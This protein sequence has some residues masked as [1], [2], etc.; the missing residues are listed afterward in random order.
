M[1]KLPLNDVGLLNYITVGWLSRT[2]WKSFKVTTD[3]E[4]DRE[5]ERDRGMFY[6]GWSHSVRRVGAQ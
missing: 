3:R 1:N 2:M 5:R 4:R 6:L